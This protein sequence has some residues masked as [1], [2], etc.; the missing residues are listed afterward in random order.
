MDQEEI[1]ER[2]EHR[3]ALLNVRQILSTVSGRAYFKY[4]FKNLEV[5]Q[6]PE[7]GLDGLLLH[8]K[9]GFL[10]AGRSIFELA[11]EAEP[12]IAAQILAQNE[13]ERYAKLI[14]SQ[15]QQG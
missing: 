11:A 14:D 9:L 15:T 12:M 4:L 5:G 10:R 7:L 1:S 3:D 8:D 13:K 6:L 2:T